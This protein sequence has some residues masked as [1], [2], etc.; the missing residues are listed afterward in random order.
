ML[1][2]RKTDCHGVNVGCCTC[3]QGR[4]SLYCFTAMLSIYMCGANAVTFIL[5]S[6]SVDVRT[7]RSKIVFSLQV[8]TLVKSW[9]KHFT[10]VPAKLTISSAVQN[11]H[12]RHSKWCFIRRKVWVSFSPPLQEAINQHLYR[13]TINPK[14]QM[15]RHHRQ[16]SSHRRQQ[17]VRR[18]T[19]SLNSI[20]PINWFAVTT[21][22]IFAVLQFAARSSRSLF[23]P[24]VF[25]RAEQQ[26]DPCAALF[27]RRSHPQKALENQ[28][29]QDNGILTINN[30]VGTDFVFVKGNNE[31]CLEIFSEIFLPGKGV[32]LHRRTW[33][34]ILRCCRQNG[35]H[36]V[37]I[38][39]GGQGLSSDVL[40]FDFLIYRFP[41]CIPIE[42]QMRTSGQEEDNMRIV[43][44]LDVLLKGQGCEHI[45]QC[46]G[47]LIKS[48]QVWIFMELMFTC[49]DKLLRKIGKPFPEEICGKIA[50]SVSFP[51]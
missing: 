42:Q 47:Y 51:L 37:P 48:T 4:I 9:Q 27:S 21:S 41:T 24:L 10:Q 33:F 20:W 15:T 34:R 19:V 40:F 49:M 13:Q 14:L 8:R 7:H 39:A 22:F 11:F 3:A 32:S 23:Q 2:Q 36:A 12:R 38:G 28:F 17:P 50:V 25:S 6:T 44:D 43:T 5:S 35:T 1:S 26:L 16:P 18:W 46:Y 30:Q 45:V 31:F 29:Q